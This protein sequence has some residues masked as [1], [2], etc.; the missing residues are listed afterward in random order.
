MRHSL[1]CACALAS[2]LVIGCGSDIPDTSF[3]LTQ[4]VQKRLESL[5]LV[6]IEKTNA[7]SSLRCV[8][9]YNG[10]SGY[11]VVSGIASSSDDYSKW[12]CGDQLTKLNCPEF[13]IKPQNGLANVTFLSGL[14][15][16]H[17]R[18]DVLACV[19]AA[20]AIAPTETRPRDAII[21]NLNSWE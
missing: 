13:V 6:T 4:D 3:S 2:L 17:S 9:G 12:G 16:E 11:F 18:N 14:K 1:L 7:V 19:N 21:A 8:S 10:W 5:E 20:I 15:S